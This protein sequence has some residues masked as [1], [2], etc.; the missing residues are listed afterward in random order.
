MRSIPRK[1][2]E[3]FVFCQA[4]VTLSDVA[5]LSA[6]QHFACAYALRKTVPFPYAVGD[7]EAVTTRRSHQGR[8][9]TED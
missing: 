4:P 2:Q 6:L 5:P 1:T 9:G 7:T 3:K 8:A